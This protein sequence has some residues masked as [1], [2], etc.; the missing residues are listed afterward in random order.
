MASLNAEEVAP[1]THKEAAVINVD[2]ND[3]S[4]I[5]D[6]EWEYEYST[7]ETEVALLLSICLEPRL[8]G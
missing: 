3:A 1:L 4:W 5:E 6:D 7:T 8:D 2:D